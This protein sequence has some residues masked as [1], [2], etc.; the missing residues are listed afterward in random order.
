MSANSSQK[1]GCAC[2]EWLRVRILKLVRFQ[3]E[4]R[5]EVNTHFPARGGPDL[6]R[7]TTDHRLGFG[8]RYIVLKGAA[9]QM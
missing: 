2:R 3:F 9:E 4:D 5:S 6:F 8:Q 7:E 1:R